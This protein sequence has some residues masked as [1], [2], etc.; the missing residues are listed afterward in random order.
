MARWNWPLIG[1]LAFCVA[2]WAV[3]AWVVRLIFA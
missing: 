1:V 2:C 3:I